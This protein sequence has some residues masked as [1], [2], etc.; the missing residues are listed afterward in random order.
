[1]VVLAVEYITTASHHSFSI[2]ITWVV[3]V[4]A[5]EEAVVEEAVVEEAAVEEV[6]VE[7][8]VPMAAAAVLFLVHNSKVVVEVPMAAAVV[9]VRCP[10]TARLRCFAGVVGPLAGSGI[11]W[12]SRMGKLLK[13]M[14]EVMLVFDDDNTCSTQFCLLN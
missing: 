11:G 12:S 9:L 6:V 14:Q 5:V 8:V 3:V 2:T 4:V 7:E 13:G 10:T 1:L